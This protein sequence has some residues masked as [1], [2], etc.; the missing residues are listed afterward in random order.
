MAGQVSPGVVIK[1]RDL[2]NA[3]I[4]NT[5]DNVGALAA[6]FERG[7]VNEM[8]NILNEK[9]LL[10]TFGRPNE[11][12]AEFWFSATNFLSYGGQLQIVRV[13]TS[14][15]VNAVSDSA[16]ATLIENDTEYVVNH[17]DGV[18]GWHYAAKT[19]GSYGNNI[20]VHAIDHGYD[21]TLGTSVALTAGAGNAAYTS[22]GA[23]GKVYT[24]P[25]GGSSLLLIETTGNFPVGSANLLVKETGAT[26]TTLNGAVASGDATITVTAAT[27]IA[28]G[29][30]LL[31]ASGEIV[32]VT[33]IA[34]AP[35]LGVDR[36]QFGTAAAAQTDGTDVFELTQA[37]ITTSMKWWDNAKLS[38]TDINWNTLVSRPGTS[39]YA[40]N[41][42]SKYDE[43]SIVV[44]DATG[45]ISG[46]KNTV[47]EKFQNL[48]KSADAQTSEGGDNYYA[49][50]L[51]F[52]SQYLYFGKHDS[53]NVTASYAGYTTGIWGSGIQDGRNYTMLG[54][55]SYT[56]AGGVDGYNVDAGDLTSGYDYFSD[57][58]SINLDYILAGPLLATRV[59]SITVAQKCINIASSRK[60]CM[61][62]VSPYKA[63][64]IGT[65]AASVE[66]QRDNVIDFFDGV[67]SPTSYAVFDSG[68]KY[69]YDRFNDTY[70][71]V[72][73]NGDVAGLCVETG[74]DLD[75]WF[76]P[77]GFTRGVLRGVI[78]LAYTPAKSD[79]DKLYQARINP[80]STF[81]GR[82]TVLYGDK[83]ALSTPSAFDRINVRR[84]FLT[85]ERQVENLG[86]NVLF[87]LNDEITRSSFANAVGGFLREVQ[88]R[89]GIT[90]Y[91]VV[92]DE[93]NNT[94]DVIDRN[95][96]VAE[97][98][99]KPSRSINFITI[100]FVATRS[101]ISFDEIVGR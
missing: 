80:I 51:R 70:R 19:A 49:S 32:K 52:A 60:D 77:A 82:G 56:L 84:L 38:G 63:A 36:G 99:L 18:Q 86:K 41:F 94:G 26:A 74:A 27:N 25:A 30:H 46:T 83:T 7:P 59:D 64:V 45:K 69:I 101:G 90:D 12:N 97:I 58:E 96:F 95:E 68:W 54:Y 73:C 43:L 37:D 33:D 62:F 57:T 48:S 2:T 50:V 4:D 47:L 67:G 100:T 3:R 17:Y 40:A 1:E 65:L 16:T 72:P 39:Q 34:S 53:T 31:L 28:V 98:Y 14:A 9:A 81:P 87:D 66:Q 78:K 15:L 6:P 21:V 11:N 71:Y 24:D 76:S 44:L 22:S 92:C 85:V 42:G 5:V 29:E 61:A 89:R 75:P 20:S 88:A 23:S 91:L 79:R 8:T 55:Q 93:T 13:G 35:D 10:D